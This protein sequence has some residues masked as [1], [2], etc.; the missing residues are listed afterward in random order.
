MN[1]KRMI[2]IGLISLIIVLLSIVIFKSVFKKTKSFDKYD[3]YSMSITVDTIKDKK[4]ESN[5]INVTDDNKNAKVTSNKVALDTYIIGNTLYYLKNR[6]FYMY[7][8]SKSYRD[9][10]DILL[11]FKS[12][13]LD[14]TRGEYTYY[15]KALNSKDINAVLECLYFGKKSSQSSLAKF[16][17][18]NNKIDEF[19]LELSDIDGYESVVINI[20]FKPLDNEYSIDTSK[21][22]GND[23][24]AGMG[25]RYKFENTKDNLY[26]IVK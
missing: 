8:F 5:I 22:Y 3:K 13:D 16:I 4:F 1:K 15:T 24:T 17:V 21:I 12:L 18:L 23:L 10:Y 7:E 6:T 19:S 25:N 11:G 9:I 20:K 14:K 2:I 26:E